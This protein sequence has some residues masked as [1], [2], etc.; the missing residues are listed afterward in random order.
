MERTTTHAGQAYTGE[1]PATTSWRPYWRQDTGLAIAVAIGYYALARLGILFQAEPENIALFW[2]AAGLS[3]GAM[4]AAGRRTRPYLAAGEILAVLAVNVGSGTEVGAS[5]VLAVHNTLESLIVALAADYVMG[6][7]REFDRL[8]RTFGFLGAAVL[9][10]AVTATSIAFILPYFE[11]D[12]SRLALWRIWVEADVVGIVTFAPL[13]IALP[14]LLRER[15]PPAVIAEGV[16]LLVVLAAAA[17]YMYIGLASSSGPFRMVPLSTMLFPLILW[18]AARTPLG[19]ATAGIAVVALVIVY[20]VVNGLGRYGDPTFP[21]PDRIVAA[22]LAMLTISVVTLA[23]AT[24]FGERKRAEASLREA[25]AEL[26]ALSTTLEHRVLERTRDL[27][28]A[29]RELTRQAVERERVT[30]EL[31]QNE[32]WLR[33]AQR[34]AGVG[35]FSLGHEQLRRQHWSEEARRILGLADGASPATI[36]AFVDTVVHPADRDR[37]RTA[38]DTAIS[39]HQVTSLEYRIVRSDGEERTVVTAVEPESTP[40]DV[41]LLC[42]ALDVT[43]RNA[44]EQKLAEYRSDLLHVVRVATAGELA[45]VMA[46]EVNQPLSAISHTASALVRLHAAGRLPA[47]ELERHLKEIASQAHRASAIISQIRQFVRKRLTAARPLDVGTVIGDVIGM[48]GSL[49]RR[50]DVRVSCMVAPDVPM[51]LGDEVQVGQLFVNLL[52]NAI[53]AVATVPVPDRQVTIEVSHRDGRKVVVEVRDRGIGIPEAVRA[54]MLDPFFTTKE[55]GL[56][57]GLPISKTIAEAHG[58]HIDIESTPGQPGTVVRVTF[59]V[60]ASTGGP[61]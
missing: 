17:A 27:S 3:A 13:F 25:N 31:R 18:I 2:P 56:G 38:L 8:A 50:Q 41:L 7:R 33:S 47:E 60:R 24:L 16:L 52:R 43:V 36:E 9:G 61:A 57:M 10:P 15:P 53:D 42:T 46:H 26:S 30:S 35:S 5:L 21:L 32:A 14:S 11:Y 51:I 12:A 28:F 54:R 58:A 6:P 39:T 59:P 4:I 34:V 45:T 44:T 49:A 55:D 23:I 48:L 1:A 20:C 37:V 40:G 22:Q 29:N 19:F